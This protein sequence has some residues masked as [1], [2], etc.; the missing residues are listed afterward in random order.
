MQQERTTS[1][2]KYQS[3]WYL[4]SGLQQMREVGRQDEQGDL[5]VVAPAKCFIRKAAAVAIKKKN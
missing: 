5:I 3:W 4:I 1:A 2:L